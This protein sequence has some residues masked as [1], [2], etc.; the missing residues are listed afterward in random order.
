LGNEWVLD[1]AAWGRPKEETVRHCQ[2]NEASILYMVIEE[3]REL[4]GEKR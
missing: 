4:P 2:S 3:T 1:K